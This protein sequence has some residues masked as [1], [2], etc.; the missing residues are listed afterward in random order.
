MD[1]YQQ[2]MRDEIETGIE[3]AVDDLRLHGNWDRWW[4]FVLTIQA[5]TKAGAYG[6]M[7]ALSK[8]AE[9]A[10]NREEYLR[11]CQGKLRIDPKTADRYIRT[12]A[13]YAREDFQGLD[14]P[15]LEQFQALPVQWQ[16]RV[17]QSLGE[18]RVTPQIVSDI[19]SADSFDQLN[20]RLRDRKGSTPRTG[21]DF[22]INPTGEVFAYFNGEI[23]PGGPVAVWTS[24]TNGRE[25]AEFVKRL[26]IR[27]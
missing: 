5:M 11:Q 24:N 25:Y 10:E 7:L 2:K 8:G 15:V 17:M 4:E 20:Q 13:L 9:L 14:E 6:T 1:A 23:V 27:S 3:Q 26:G 19:L 21:T 22:W 18:E 16:I 12:V